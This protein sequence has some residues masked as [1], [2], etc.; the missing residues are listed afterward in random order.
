MNN[1]KSSKHM[2]GASGPVCSE[3]SNA[4]RCVQKGEAHTF[5]VQ[6]VAAQALR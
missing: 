6:A 1:F 2:H 4:L 3:C 5:L